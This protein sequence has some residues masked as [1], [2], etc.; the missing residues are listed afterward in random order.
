MVY[1]K[2]KC[3]CGTDLIWWS[4]PVFTVR[5]HINKNGKKAKNPIKLGKSYEGETVYER[6]TCVNCDKEYEIEFD[7]RDRII[8]GA[9]MN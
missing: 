2:P 3:D 1:Q 9:E 6:L 8:R 7:D 4:Q 5:Y